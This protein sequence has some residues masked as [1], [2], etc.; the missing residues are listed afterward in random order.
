MGYPVLIIDDHEL[1]STSLR[2]ALRGHGIEAHQVTPDS[3]QSILD[4]AATITPG[5]A[6]LDLD[7]GTGVDGQWLRGAEA[8]AG[9]R[10]LAWKVLIVS[11]SNPDQPQTAAAIAAG[12]IGAVP[13]SSSF[14]TLLRT[15]VKAAAGQPVMTEVD[16]QR[17]LARDRDYRAQERE[18]TQKLSR[19]SP[20]EREV[21]DLLAEGHRAAVIADQFVVSMT[22][23][24]TQ[25]R[26]ILAKL[27]VNS[28]LEAVA[29]VRQAPPQAPQE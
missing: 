18:L 4:R 11:G 7:L 9:L 26:S 29:I 27:E 13:K 23:V 8:V 15:V 2:M 22:T 17:W 21:L 16:Y 14:D 24:R 10:E 19:L 1:F 20:R 25:I 5:L 28:Q 12:A 3:Y 6:V